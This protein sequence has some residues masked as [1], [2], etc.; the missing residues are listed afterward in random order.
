MSGTVENTGRPVL[1]RQLAAQAIV[2]YFLANADAGNH[3]VNDELVVELA[4]RHRAEHAHSVIA[5]VCGNDAGAAAQIEK[6][7]RSNT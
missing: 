5:M 3:A 7:H 1:T 6:K 4:R 2:D